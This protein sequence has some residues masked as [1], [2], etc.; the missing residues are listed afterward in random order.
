MT[1]ANECESHDGEPKKRELLPTGDKASEI[2][3]VLV[4]MY[5]AIHNPEDTAN[6]DD[7]SERANQRRNAEKKG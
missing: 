5:R 1:W 2:V 6:D 7:S 3:E 4:A